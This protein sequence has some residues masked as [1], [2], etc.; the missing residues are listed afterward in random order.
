M[1]HP[2]QQSCDLCKWCALY[3]HSRIVYPTIRWYNRPRAW[4]DTFFMPFLTRI[5]ACRQYIDGECTRRARS[6]WEK[7]SPW[8]HKDQSS[9]PQKLVTSGCCCPCV[10]SVLTRWDG[11]LRTSWLARLNQDTKLWIKLRGSASMD[12]K[13]SYQRN[14]QLQPQASAYVYTYM[15]VHTHI[16]LYTYKYIY[17]HVH[18]MHTYTWKIRKKTY[19]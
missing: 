12:N 10:I 13:E 6:Q 3:R 11:S 8:K 17:I 16:C 2:P 7:S 15:H 19:I 1:V 9:N 4:V 5:W 18:T 14:I